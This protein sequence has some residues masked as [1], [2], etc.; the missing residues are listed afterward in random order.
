MIL[1]IVHTERLPQVFPSSLIILRDFC[2]TVFKF[3][4]SKMMQLLCCIP[5]VMLFCYCT[6]GRL[7]P[8]FF[9]KV[10]NYSVHFKRELGRKLTQMKHGQAGMRSKLEQSGELN[11]QAKQ[12]QTRTSLVHMVMLNFA[13]LRTL[14]KRDESLSQEKEHLTDPKRGQT[15]LQF[16]LS[17]RLVLEVPDF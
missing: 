17:L 16:L 12:L 8:T 3:T 14:M 2:Q 1:V 9:S 5:P 11:Y 13:S 15:A 4:G 10:T 7:V 6:R